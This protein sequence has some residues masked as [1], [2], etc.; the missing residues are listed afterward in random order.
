MGDLGAFDY[1]VATYM[2]APAVYQRHDA[3]MA[4]GAVSAAKLQLASVL[5]RLEG[6]G[7]VIPIH[8]KAFYEFI[9][10]AEP[11]HVARTVIRLQRWGDVLNGVRQVAPANYHHRLGEAPRFSRWGA[12]GH[13]AN[14]GETYAIHEGAVGG[15]KAS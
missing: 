6:R 4:F 7:N 15:T 8:V 11:I 13:A 10:V 9:F 12:K 2:G 1:P 3:G 5:L 14:R